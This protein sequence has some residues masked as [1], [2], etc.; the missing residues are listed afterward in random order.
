[1]FA[2]V[3]MMSGSNP[4]VSLSE[5][6]YKK[7]SEIFRENEPAECVYQVWTGAV[8]RYKLLGWSSADRRISFA[9][10]CLWI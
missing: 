6:T 8:R 2:R 4:S 9:R 7:G 5:F 10:R 3:S 1:M